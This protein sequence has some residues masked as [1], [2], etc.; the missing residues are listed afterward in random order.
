[1]GAASARLLVGQA[2]DDEL[3]S[4]LSLLSEEDQAKLRNVLTTAKTVTA[5]QAS[6]T[7][8]EYAA[9]FERLEET[10]EADW[11][12]VYADMFSPDDKNPDSR[13]FVD[14]TDGKLQ[15]S[16]DTGSEKWGRRFDPTTEVNPTLAVTDVGSVRKTSFKS[17][18]PKDAPVWPQVEAGAL[19]FTLTLGTAF[20]ER[21]IKWNGLYDGKGGEF[22]GNMAPPTDCDNFWRLVSK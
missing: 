11:C 3:K 15:V 6:K 2:T 13:R 14:L 19:N 8:E 16:A 4:A 12:G 17:K 20:G 5:E 10:K 18:V 9:A 1:M 7:K 21:V 22:G